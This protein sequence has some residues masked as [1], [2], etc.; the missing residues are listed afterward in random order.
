MKKYKHL[1]FD[2]DKTLWDF[3]ENTKDTFKDLFNF[4]KLNEKGIPYVKIFHDTYNKHNDELWDKYRK[5]LVVKSFLIVQRYILTLSDFNIFD[6]KLAEDLSKDYLRISP[7]KTKLIPYAQQALQY[8]SK[9]YSLHIITN[10]FNE[11]QYIKV[12]KSNIK[13]YFD[14][15]ITSE[16]AGFNKPNKNIFLYSLNKTGALVN[17]SLMIGDAIDVD[18]TGAQ[19]IGMDQVFYNPKNISTPINSTFEINSLKEL[20]NIL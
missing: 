19:S 5:G 20:I 16:E 14:K 2:L 15:I 18:I 6:N 17:E 10:G 11:V 13:K 9:K 1:F 8:L 7:L 4:Y 3:D 12:E